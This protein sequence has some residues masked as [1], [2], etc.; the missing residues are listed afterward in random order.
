MYTNYTYGKFRRDFGKPCQFQMYGPIELENLFP[1]PT[2]EEM[3]LLKNPIDNSTLITVEKSAH[4]VS[5]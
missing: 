4:E 2:K 5:L 3:W 1:D